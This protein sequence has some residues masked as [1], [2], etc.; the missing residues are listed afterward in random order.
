MCLGGGDADNV[1]LKV[2]QALR[3]VDVGE[4]EVIVVSGASN[5][6]HP[7]LQSA[8]RDIP[9]SLRLVSNVTE[10]PELM[11]WADVAV[12]GGGIM[13]WERLFMGLPSLIIVLAENQAPI[14]EHLNTAGVA[15]NLGQY[16][17]LSSS[18]LVQVLKQ[19]LLTVEMREEMGRRGQELVNG[20]GAVLV[21]ATLT[22]A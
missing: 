16:V 20:E 11:A 3:L 19:L 2:I 17:T 5:P 6:H 18:G 8:V 22:N 9:F 13:S 14:A 1:T 21:I 10:M 7:E 4:L 12:A 15:I